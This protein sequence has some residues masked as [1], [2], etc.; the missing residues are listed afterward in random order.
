MKT[1]KELCKGINKM[2]IGAVIHLMDGSLFFCYCKYIE[3]KQK[4]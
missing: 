3:S 2:L 1:I 4:G